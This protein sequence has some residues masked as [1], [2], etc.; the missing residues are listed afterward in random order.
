MN[1][2]PSIFSEQDSHRSHGTP[3]NSPVNPAGRGRHP[4]SRWY[5]VRTYPRHEKPVRDRIAGR[6]F[7]CYLPLF[8]T[9]HRWKNG[10]KV[11]LDLPLFPSYLFVDI[12]YPSR[13]RVLDIPGV[14]SLVGAAKNPTP[15]PDADIEA[16]RNGLHLRNPQPH[17][18][19]TQG[20]SILI[21]KGP[22]AGLTG[23]LVRKKEGLRVVLSVEM[24]MQ[25]VAV[26]VSAEDIE[27]VAPASIASPPA[28]KSGFHR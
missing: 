15:V 18:R 7:D 21:T 16:L 26:E 28:M 12:D 3:P 27:V 8:Q 24:L 10:C 17:A 6:N 11:Q 5:A 13:G 14:H 2:A 1:M 22:L 19:L 9:V 23:V 25:A 4:D 20:Q